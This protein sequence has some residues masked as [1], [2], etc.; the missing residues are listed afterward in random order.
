MSTN[1]WYP[2][3]LAAVLSGDVDVLA[4]TIKVALIDDTYT[5]SASH[6]FYDDVS[7]KVLG[8]PQTLGTKTVSGG[9]FSA[10]NATFT[11]VTAG[12]TVAGFVV[13][14]DTGTPGTSQL[15]GYVANRS[16]SVPIDIDTSGGNITLAWPSGVVLKI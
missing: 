13:Y 1:T 5:Y 15:L 11:A 9:N 7:A 2:T 4:D 16:D 3:G 14:K 8:T 6:D 10:A 12:D